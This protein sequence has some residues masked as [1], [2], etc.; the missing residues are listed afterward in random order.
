MMP[1]C[2]SRYHT[3]GNTSKSF[4]RDS[5]VSKRKSA[6][7]LSLCRQPHVYP[8]RGVALA[9]SNNLSSGRT[10]EDCC[11]F[12]AALRKD[13]NAHTDI[14]T[15]HITGSPGSGKGSPIALGIRT[16]PTDNNQHYNISRHKNFRQV[17]PANCDRRPCLRRKVST[18]S[19]GRSP[20]R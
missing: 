15:L 13:W 14:H 9:N 1:N 10:Q 16:E 11:V 20:T 7:G 2:K 18:L 3:T 17:Y 19:S 4:T 8:L 12:F 5:T 6:G